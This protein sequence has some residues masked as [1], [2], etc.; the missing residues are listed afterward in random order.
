MR[1]AA[2]IALLLGGCTFG[3]GP[4]MGY[5]AGKGTVGWQLG[6][7]AMGHDDT[8]GGQGSLDVGQSYR[9]GH[10]VTYGQFSVGRFLMDQDR[11]GMHYGIDGH[12]GYGR[13]DGD[14][15]LVAGAAPFV[16]RFHGDYCDE[17]G[18]FWSASL[19]IGLRAI[20]GEL[21]VFVAPRLTGILS[22]FCAVAD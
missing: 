15:H 5:R 6:V 8:T 22:P 2:V 19:S 9:D 4:V 3:A 11:E 17:G 1:R 14:S 20:A 12:L 16:G 18:T 7:G 10:H 21:E 13:G